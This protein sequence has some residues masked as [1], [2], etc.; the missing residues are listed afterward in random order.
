[1]SPAEVSTPRGIEPNVG[2]TNVRIF[3]TRHQGAPSQEIADALSIVMSPVRFVLVP[4][5]FLNYSARSNA[6]FR[7]KLPT[8]SALRQLPS[9]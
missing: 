4:K 2:E 3:D 5:S 8:I 6:A 9:R 1:M 7:A